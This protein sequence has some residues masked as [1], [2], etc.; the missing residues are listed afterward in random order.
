MPD[1]GLLAFTGFDPALE[2]EGDDEGQ[3]ILTTAGAGDIAMVR[4]SQEGEIQWMY[5][6]GNE[7]Y[8]SAAALAQLDGE[9]LW[10]T[11]IYSSDPFVATSG[12]D[13]DVPLPLAGV[14][15]IF[16]MRFDAT[17]PAE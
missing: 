1:G 11:G 13:D 16:L 14:S 5:R 6:M 15:D 3:R 10:I 7:A 9:S 17:E 8:E 12:H 2:F 4:F